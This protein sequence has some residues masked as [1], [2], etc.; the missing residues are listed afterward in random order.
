MTSLSLR[1][2]ERD[3]LPDAVIRFGIRRLLAGR[4]RDERKSDV[5]A[6]QASLMR[7]VERLRESPVA[8]ATR[9][10]PTS[11]TM[12]CRRRSSSRSWAGT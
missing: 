3:L 6:Q 1:L 11:S 8:I 7:L 12:K 5:E 2:L 10:R 4:L 9:A